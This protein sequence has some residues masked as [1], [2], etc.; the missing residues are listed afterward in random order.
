MAPT[1]QIEV[2]AIVFEQ[3]EKDLEAILSEVALD[4]IL[5][6]GFRNIKVGFHQDTLRRE[7]VNLYG[8]CPLVSNRDAEII[9]GRV[10]VD[11]FS[12]GKYNSGRNGQT[13]FISSGGAHC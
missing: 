1:S 8:V 12:E 11:L 6:I 7:H 10:A 9:A 4:N 13:I 2:G 3:L 5:D